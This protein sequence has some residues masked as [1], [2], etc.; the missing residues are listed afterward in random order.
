MK[1]TFVAG[2]RFPR[3]P[4][5][6]S[7][8]RRRPHGRPTHRGRRPTIRRRLS[9]RRSST[10]AGTAGPRSCAGSSTAASTPTSRPTSGGP[11]C[12]G[13]S[14]PAIRR[15]RGLAGNGFVATLAAMAA[16]TFAA[17][18]PGRRRRLPGPDGGETIPLPR[19]AVVTGF[20][21]VV[22]IVIAAALLRWSARPAER[23]MWM[24]S[25]VPACLSGAN[26][27]T[28]GRP[29]GLSRSGWMRPRP[30]GGSGP[31]CRAPCRPAGR[32]S[33]WRRPR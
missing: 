20:F 33:S 14:R 6:P 8:G 17:A 12:T 27:A 21:S 19:F 29:G 9:G 26:T 32:R 22:G 11:S 1:W 25:L 28:T 18:R 23:F 7:Q 15:L 13:R 31:R 4:R 24:A 16:T 3:Q 10:S 5:P 2:A 30:G